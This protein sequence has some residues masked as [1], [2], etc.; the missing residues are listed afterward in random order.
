MNHCAICVYSHVVLTSGPRDL[1]FSVQVPEN[2]ACCLFRA[3]VVPGC[4]FLID[5]FAHRYPVG[6]PTLAS[7][8]MKGC[9]WTAKGVLIPPYRLGS[10]TPSFAVDPDRPGITEQLASPEL[11]AELRGLYMS[12]DIRLEGFYDR[13]DSRFVNT[14]PISPDPGVEPA[15]S[16]ETVKPRYLPLGIGEHNIGSN[17]GLIANLI[18]LA[19]TQ[20]EM[21]C[22]VPL[23]ADSN[24]F[25]RVLS[26]DSLFFF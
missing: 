9:Q 3:P 26:V 12:I 2:R 23:V 1:Q 22:Y 19:K 21:K 10:E 11:T 15:W 17:V 4:V 13:S 16:R 25:K 7:G 6:V 20:T 24:I 18:E 14:V 5:N 8:V